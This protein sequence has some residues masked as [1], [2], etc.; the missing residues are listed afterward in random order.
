[1]DRIDV[2]ACLWALSARCAGLSETVDVLS[3]KLGRPGLEACIERSKD[4]PLD[5]VIHLYAYKKPI[6]KSKGVDMIAVDR[7][8]RIVIPVCARWRRCSALLIA[9]HYSEQHVISPSEFLARCSAL[10]IAKHY[11]EQHVIS[12]SE[13]LSISRYLT[14]PV[15]EEF[16]IREETEGSYVF[17]GTSMTQFHSKLPPPSSWKLPGMHSLVIQNLYPSTLLP[18][19]RA[20]LRS[21][22]VSY[23]KRNVTRQ[24]DEGMRAF[25]DAT[26]LTSLRLSFDNCHFCKDYINDQHVGLRHVK[27]LHIDFL[28]CSQSAR[29]NENLWKSFLPIQFPGVVDLTV[30]LD[31][32]DSTFVLQNGSQLYDVTL[33]SLLLTK[34]SLPCHFP[35][36]ETLDVEA[37]PR[38]GDT[39]P[40]LILLLPYCCLPSLKHLRIRSSSSL[41]ISDEVRETAWLPSQF[42]I[43]SEVFPIALE[44]ITLDLPGVGEVV[45]WVQKLVSKMKDR[46]RWDGFTGL[47]VK[48]GR[49]TFQFIPRDEVERWCEENGA[50]VKKTAQVSFVLKLQYLIGMCFADAVIRGALN[51]FNFGFIK[52]PWILVVLNIIWLTFLVSTFKRTEI[53][54][55]RTKL[56]RLLLLQAC[57][58]ILNV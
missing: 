38:R 22:A 39:D 16:A 13:F 6:G 17:P 2:D 29:N 36:L 32:G 35:C 21:L 23:V 5:V 48:K 1:M 56:P 8:A 3:R 42:P 50:G 10:L 49:D 9:K 43:G 52:F 15:L 26:F 30:L 18:K 53:Y 44:T 34:T 41:T 40:A 51:P 24:L 14:A 47:T 25:A 54:L 45:H 20:Q 27:S 28:G 46:F 33:H 11:S 58:D 31:I 37:R 4:K 12:P 7:I 55:I 19:Y 57:I